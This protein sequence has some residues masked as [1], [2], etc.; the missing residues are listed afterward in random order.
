LNSESECKSGRCQ[1]GLCA[2]IV[3]V[4]GAFLIVAGLVW[5][6]RS[7]TRPE[8]LGVDRAAFRRKSLAELRAANTE[9]LTSYGWQD[10]TRGVVRLPIVE[11]MKLVEHEWHN[12]AAARSNLIAR[13]EKATAPLPKAPEKPSQFE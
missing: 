2:Y 6:M 10:Q 4:I 11:A 1:S 5:I 9:A 8:P 13:V 12:A 3:A 7:Y